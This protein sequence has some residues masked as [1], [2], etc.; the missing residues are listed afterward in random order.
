MDLLNSK[1]QA[2]KTVPPE[3][4]H[5]SSDHVSTNSNDHTT[6]TNF[7]DHPTSLSRKIFAL[8]ISKWRFALKNQECVFVDV[9]QWGNLQFYVSQEVALSES[10]LL[11]L[12][13]NAFQQ[14]VGL[15]Q[16][17]PSCVR[18][19]ITNLILLHNKLFSA[20]FSK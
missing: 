10:A 13:R 14:R 2:G 4:Y 19:L 6:Q 16:N 3:G 18:P 1:E 12:S 11:N 7:C 15:A 17:G 20:S 8:F 5:D 9:I